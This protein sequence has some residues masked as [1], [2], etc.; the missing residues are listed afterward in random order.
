MA[1]EN[2]KKK[3]TH[4]KRSNSTSTWVPLT[5]AEIK[6]FKLSRAKFYSCDKA[7]KVLKP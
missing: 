3:R 5:A 1:A 2:T 4:I 6:R 7:S